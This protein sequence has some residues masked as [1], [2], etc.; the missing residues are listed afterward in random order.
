MIKCVVLKN[1]SL[2]ITAGNKTR[3][4]IK[5]LQNQATGRVWNYWE[6]MQALFEGYACNSSF[7]HFDPSNAN[8]FI[9]LTS[10]PCIAESIQYNDD[11]TDEVIGRLW[12]FADSTMRDDLEELKNKG[13]VV[14]QLV[15][16]DKE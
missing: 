8:P 6:I 16:E 13:F 3:E 15:Q 5:E 2:K 14:Y 10:A 7:T 11:G 12:Y 4:L 1:G 9:G